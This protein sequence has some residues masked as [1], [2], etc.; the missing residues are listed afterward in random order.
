MKQNSII[1]LREALEVWRIS[2]TSFY[3]RINADAPNFDPE[4]PR[5]FPLGDGPNSKRAFTAADVQSYLDV[6]VQRGRAKA[7]QS[8]AE[9]RERA[10]VLVTART[11]RRTARTGE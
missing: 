3:G 4:C 5:P 9:A 6:I 8:A 7:E 2:R 10:K 1:E 11:A